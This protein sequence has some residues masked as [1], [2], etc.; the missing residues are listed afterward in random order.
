MH[1]KRLEIRNFKSFKKVAIPFYSDF[2]AISGP[3]G[4]GKSNIIDAIVFVLGISRSKGMR[5]EK[6]TDLIFK[7]NGIEESHAEVSLVL[8]NDDG[9]LRFDGDEVKIKR[10]IKRQIMDII[11]IIT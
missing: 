6:L 9:T 5:A 11:A 10:N 1:I 4:C 2:T 3:N 8:D 7:G